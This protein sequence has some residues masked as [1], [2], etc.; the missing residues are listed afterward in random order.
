MTHKL[1]L[2][3][4]I[5][6]KKEYLKGYIWNRLYLDLGFWVVAEGKAMTQQGWILLWHL[7]FSWLQAKLEDYASSSYILPGNSKRQK[8]YPK[9]S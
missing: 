1:V 3:F 2:S 7:T 9:T 6:K 5:K 8:V 4:E